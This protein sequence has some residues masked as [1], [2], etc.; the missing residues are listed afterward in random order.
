LLEEILQ[1]RRPRTQFIIYP[2]GQGPH[3]LLLD[4]QKSNPTGGQSKST[5]QCICI[6]SA[7]NIAQFGFLEAL[8]LFFKE[9]KSF[10]DG[11]NS[12]VDII[13]CQADL[14]KDL[15]NCAVYCFAFASIV[16]KI[17]F[18]HFKKPEYQIPPPRSNDSDQVK[19]V[20]L[21]MKDQGIPFFLLQALGE[22]AMLMA[23]SLEQINKLLTEDYLIKNPLPPHNNSAAAESARQLVAKNS[24]QQ[25]LDKWKKS[26][27]LEFGAQNS[28]RLTYI[29]LREKR[30][31]E[32]EK[33]G[34]LLSLNAAMEGVR[35]EKKNPSD[36]PEELTLGQALRRYA[37][38]KGPNEGWLT[39]LD[40]AIS[41]GVL[42]EGKTITK[43]GEKPFTALDFAVERG[44]ASRALDLHKRG[45]KS[46]VELNK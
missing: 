39:I 16:S 30:L 43:S 33:L 38:G 14:Q 41:A 8:K 37:A 6:E 11:N 17:P 29:E 23:Q 7:K 42:N 2:N 15:N 1:G 19:L 26:H 46:W 24:T 3:A 27:S 32:K 20:R 40:T 22:K 4:V 9:K 36:P 10:F 5:L 28:K 45:A 35:A 44:Q 25:T 31:G 13:G 12:E 21:F 34:P 18:S